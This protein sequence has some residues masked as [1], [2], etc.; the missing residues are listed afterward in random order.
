MSYIAKTLLPNEKVIY[1]SHPHWIIVFRPLVG[2]VILLAFFPLLIGNHYA[3][4]IISFF[5]LLGLIICLSELIIYYSSEFGI[6]D[7]R[8]IMKSGFINRYAFE[9]SLDRI[10]GV[11]IKQSIMGRILDYGSIRIHEISGTNELFSAINHP[12]RFRYKILEEIEK[13]KKSNRII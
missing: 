6:T 5:T 1:H 3:I 9:N 12:F 2:S 13:H 4:W 10:E 11:E 7:K 8:V